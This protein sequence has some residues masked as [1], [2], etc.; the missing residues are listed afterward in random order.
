VWED[1]KIRKQEEDI[2]KKPTDNDDIT[3][4]SSDHTPEDNRAS[5]S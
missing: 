2:T 5:T 1:Q 3:Q 4:S